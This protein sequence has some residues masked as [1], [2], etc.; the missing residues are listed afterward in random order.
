MSRSRSR[1]LS[2]S[3][4][5]SVSPKRSEKLAVAG[6]FTKS[7]KIKSADLFDDFFAPSATATS[8]NICIR[9]DLSVTVQVC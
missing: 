6:A 3:R 1:S 8:I 7:S 5:R 4:S 2:R 9:W